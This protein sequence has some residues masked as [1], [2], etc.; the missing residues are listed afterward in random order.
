MGG[1][2]VRGAGLFRLQLSPSH[3]LHSLTTYLCAKRTPNQGA[4]GNQKGEHSPTPSLQW[5]YLVQ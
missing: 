2:R 4:S 3:L 1:E 5:V